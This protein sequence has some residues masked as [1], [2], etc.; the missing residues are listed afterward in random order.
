MRSDPQIEMGGSAGQ[1]D[2]LRLQ[3]LTGESAG[4][5]VLFREY[6][7]RYHYQGYALRRAF[8]LPGT[9]PAASGPGAGMSV[10]DFT[11]LETSRTRPMDRMGH[12]PASAQSAI[13]RQSQSFSHP[14]LGAGER[15]G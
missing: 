5:S 9:F 3:L 11:C 4:D 12:Y 14:A 1:Y 15:L 2:P 6:I 13:D 7:D 8:A 10:V